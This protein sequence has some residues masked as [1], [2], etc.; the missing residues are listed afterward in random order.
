MI[1]ALR[2]DRNVESLWDGRRPGGDLRREEV[3]S[4]GLNDFDLLWIAVLDL[5][6]VSRRLLACEGAE[7]QDLVVRVLDVDLED[8]R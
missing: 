3:L 2:T 7:D 5:A 1:A 8:Q 6:I 4:L